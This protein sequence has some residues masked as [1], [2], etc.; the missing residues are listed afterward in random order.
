MDIPLRCYI[1]PPIPPL[2]DF[3][4]IPSHNDLESDLDISSPSGDRNKIYY[5]GICIEVKSTR[6]LATLSPDCHGFF[7]ASS[8]VFCDFFVPQELQILSFIWESDIQILST[9]VYL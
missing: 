1:M 3:D 6:F 4:F 8:A 5:P 7:E 2:L 9:N